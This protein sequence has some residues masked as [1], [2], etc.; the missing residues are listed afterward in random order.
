[1]NYL[2]HGAG[3]PR[4]PDAETH[5]FVV[6][7][8][9]HGV[10]TRGTPAETYFKQRG[11]PWLIDCKDLRYYDRCPHPAKDASGNRLGLRFPAVVALLRDPRD[12]IGGALRIFFTIP[13]GSEIE[14]RATLGHVAGNAAHLH[15]AA[16]ELV[17]AEG[18]ET[19]ASAA[20]LLGMPAWAA[21][22]AGNLAWS[23]RL[24]ALPRAFAVVIATD[25]DPA[26]RKASR[27][28]ARR[29]RAEG[30]TVRLARPDTTGADFNDVL[31][32]RLATEAARHE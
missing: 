1:M 28:A 7:F 20:F 14:R 16:H 26:G 9:R 25:A 15:P 19:A 31:V 17:V 5:A 13:K 8:W 3:R 29:W 10:P 24:P 4:S 6:S 27:L 22:G 23:M 11:L 30:R 2:R 18:L 12:N 21:A 32:A